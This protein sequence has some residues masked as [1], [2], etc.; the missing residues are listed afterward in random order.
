MSLKRNGT[1]RV[2][3][4]YL[5]TCN[6]FA[7]TAAVTLRVNQ[8]SVNGTV[9]Q[10]V[11]LSAS[12]TVSDSD[13]YLRITWI[14]TG[15]RIVQYKCLPKSD[16]TERGYYTISDHYKHRVEFPPENASLLL[17]DLQFND[18][19]IYEL[20]IAD[21]GGTRTTKLTL[22][23]QPQSGSRMDAKR[24]SVLEV[25]LPPVGLAV[26]L[27]VL[28]LIVK[29]RRGCKRTQKQTGERNDP[30]DSRISGILYR[31]IYVLI[32]GDII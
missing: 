5:F 1:S 8:D 25:I 32:I 12:Y 14:K 6:L 15:T 23:V 11:L 31:K 16:N 10:S 28:C 13:G 4:V 18:S 26:F 17:K 27:I 7:L 24:T 9:G 2:C 19:G 3:A 22:T 30:E 29:M 20:T 21:S